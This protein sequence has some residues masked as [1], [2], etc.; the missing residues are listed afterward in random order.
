MGINWTDIIISLGTLLIGGGGLLTLV[1]LKDKKYSA[2]LENVK[3][4]MENSSKTNEEWKQIAEQ[5]RGEC[6]EY[7][8]SLDKKEAKIDAMYNCV[9][10]WRNKADNLNSQ[11]IESNLLRCDRLDCPDRRPP[12]GSMNDTKKKEDRPCTL[13]KS[14]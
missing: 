3:S 10:E 4:A 1:T 2:I 7:K 8:V 14:R 9:S 12:F 11:L 5:W 6:Q 13:Q